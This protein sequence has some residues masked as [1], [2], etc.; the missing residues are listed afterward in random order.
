M[1]KLK[2]TAVV[3]L[4]NPN[5]NILSNI[6]SYINTVNRIILCDNSK[7]NNEAL[8]T[9]FDNIIYVFNNKN[10]GLSKAFNK[11]LNNK[12]FGWEDDEFIIFFDQDSKVKD[13]HISKLVDVFF[14]LADKGVNVGCVGPAYFNTISN[15][16]EMVKRK[17]HILFDTI[18]V[19]TMITSSMLTT[20]ENLTKIGLFNE[21]VFLDMAD[22]DLC[23][24]FTNKNYRCCVTMRTVFE[25]S[26]GEGIKQFGPYKIRVW[27]P[28]REYYQVRDSLY[29]LHQSYVPYQSKVR[30]ILMATLVPLIKVFL[31]ENK[32]ERVKYIKRG[33]RDYFN[34]VSGGI[35]E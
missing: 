10:L 1:F 13:E 35:F 26:V 30:L 2:I 33:Y 29:L 4:Y 7:N 32:S 24:R 11:I 25:H 28:F 6:T 14:E 34:G 9:D 5:K 31:L 15:K 8:F 23:W 27:K 21:K 18:L 19:P 16:V 3:T 20:Y 12:D 17:K 22:W